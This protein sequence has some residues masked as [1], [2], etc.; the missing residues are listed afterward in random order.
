[1][2]GELA[3]VGETGA[4]GDLR[5][6]KVASLKESLGPFNAAHNDVLVQD[7]ALAGAPRPRGNRAKPSGFRI[8]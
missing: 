8:R 6:R 3:L 1:M 7:E 4:G 2:V 5:Q